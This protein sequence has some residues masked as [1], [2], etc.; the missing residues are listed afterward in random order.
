MSRI[1]AKQG[2]Y[3]VNPEKIFRKTGEKDWLCSSFMRRKFLLLYLTYLKSKYVAVIF[4]L[5]N[6]LRSCIL[7]L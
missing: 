5:P 7:I 2:Q 6:R 3:P 4:P 1:T